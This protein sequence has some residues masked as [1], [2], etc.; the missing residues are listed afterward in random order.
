MA[1]QQHP[2][3]ALPGS[4]AEASF[5]SLLPVAAG[6]EASNA[7]ASDAY[8]DRVPA[9]TF[10]QLPSLQPHRASAVTV[11]Q[12]NG[13]VTFLDC[14][15]ISRSFL[16]GKTLADCLMGKV[17]L[18]RQH[19]LGA[20]GSRSDTGVA[21]AIKVMLKS[22]IR[23][24]VTRDGRPVAENPEEEI[25]AMMF[26]GPHPHLLNLQ[27]LATDEAHVFLVMDLAPGGDLFGRVSMNA[28]PQS[29]LAEDDARRYFLQLALGVQY[30]H[31]RGIVHR[32]LSLENVMLDA[33]DCVK[34]IDFGLMKQVTLPAGGPLNGQRVGKG[35]Y[36]PPEVY[37]ANRLADARSVDVWC[38][39]VMLFIML[40]GV[41]PYRTAD[42]ARCRLF[43]ELAGGRLLR[44][45]THWGMDGHAS[46]EAKDLV[47]RMLQPVAADRPSLA[48]ILQHPWLAEH[49]AEYRHAV[50]PGTNH[51]E[52]VEWMEGAT[53]EAQ[54]TGG[55][56]CLSAERVAS[57]PGDWG[58]QWRKQHGLSAVVA[59]AATP[60]T[61]GS[62]EWTSTP[63]VLPSDVSGGGGGA[64]GSLRISA[65]PHQDEDGD[66]LG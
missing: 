53:A 7:A 6:V 31:A 43:A 52:L 17:K 1:A 3:A 29:R 15:A 10:S 37:K 62:G 33:N 2:A 39:G 36:M 25:Q 42:A 13:N 35:G 22:C 41:P 66:I 59:A 19:T 28:Q 65:P 57:A 21:V 48:E 27:A 18:A 55:A 4:N 51:D 30:M 34:V 49:H 32:D 38:I 20:D 58:V 63:V 24:R 26:L 11:S 16:L 61:P 46:A 14:P 23:G 47:V 12:P 45:L 60:P 40:F 9:S 64:G 56:G 54:A 8:A 5:S 50:F 44:L